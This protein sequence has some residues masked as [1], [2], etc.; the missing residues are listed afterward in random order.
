MPMRKK[1]HACTRQIMMG[2]KKYC[3][4]HSQAFDSLQEKYK[5]WRNA[6][7]EI[8]WIDYVNTLFKLDETGGWIKEVIITEL[9]ESKI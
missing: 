6:Y 9:K 1:C 4:Y 3:I 2:G 8:S 7:G 5:A